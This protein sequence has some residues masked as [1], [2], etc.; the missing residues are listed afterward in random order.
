MSVIDDYLKDVPSPQKEIL[1]HVREVIKETV[2]DAEDTISYGM[3]GFKYKKKYLVT[4]NAFK[5]HMSFFPGSYVP[6]ELEARAA[7][8]KKSKGT[9][10]F[11]P[12]TPIPDELVRDMAL[13]RVKEINKK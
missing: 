7:P 9:F 10:Q 4:F 3:P 13:A 8:F 6:P 5:D 12:E 1:Q 11:T 2:P